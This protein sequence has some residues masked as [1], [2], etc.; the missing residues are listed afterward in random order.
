MSFD[1]SVKSKYLQCHGAALPRYGVTLSFHNASLC[2]DAQ[3]LVVLP[4]YGAALACA[5]WRYYRYMV[6]QY[7]AIRVV[8]AVSP[9]CGCLRVQLIVAEPTHGAALAGAVWLY[10]YCC[11]GQHFSVVLIAGEASPSCA[12]LRVQLLIAVRTYGA[13]LA[14]AMWRYC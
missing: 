4:V 8:G 11:K 5:V 3:L 14:C 7:L 2:S 12:C 1:Q 9:R 10:M 13:A 6:Q